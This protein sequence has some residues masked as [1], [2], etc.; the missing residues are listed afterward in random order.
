MN[1]TNQEITAGSKTITFAVQLL[2]SSGQLI[3][4]Y[5]NGSINATL[6]GN[7]NDGFNCTLGTLTLTKFGTFTG[8]ATLSL[9]SGSFSFEME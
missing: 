4:T 3:G 5:S 6:T 9:Q 7:A 2:N 1:F 8:P